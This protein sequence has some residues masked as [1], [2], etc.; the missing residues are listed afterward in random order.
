[1]QVE[2]YEKKGT[3]DTLLHPPLFCAGISALPAIGDY[4]NLP[5]D[6]GSLIYVAKVIDRHWDFSEEKSVIRIVVEG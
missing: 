2:F 4:V 3:V 5:T 6:K 1:M